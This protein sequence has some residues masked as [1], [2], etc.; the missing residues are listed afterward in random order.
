[1]TGQ[2]TFAPLLEGFFTQRLMRQRRASAHTIASY[3]D[4]FQMLLQFVHERLRKAPSVLMLEDIDAPLVAAFLDDLE[5]KRRIT[6]RTRNLRLT[7][8]HS[9]FQYRRAYAASSLGCSGVPFRAG[10]QNDSRSVLGDEV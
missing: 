10:R 6:A 3:R 7:A 9:F 2:P 8:I 4:S 1:M 5:A